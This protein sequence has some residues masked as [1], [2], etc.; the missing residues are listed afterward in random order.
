MAAAAAPSV[1]EDGEDMETAGQEGG[2]KTVG[3][4]GKTLEDGKMMD[5]KAVE[6]QMMNRGGLKLS[7]LVGRLREGE[8]PITS[9][10][11]RKSSVVRVGDWICKDKVCEWNNFAW[12]RECQKCQKNR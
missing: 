4:R 9:T 5:R 6:G 11:R 1:Q 3:P 10:P 12:R 8:E 7:G 2:W